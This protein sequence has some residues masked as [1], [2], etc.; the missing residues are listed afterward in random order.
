MTSS[1]RDFRM[2]S[3]MHQVSLKMQLRCLQKL[4]M[5]RRSELRKLL[6]RNSR[7]LTRPTSTPS[8]QQWHRLPSSTTPLQHHSHQQQTPSHK[9]QIHSAQQQLP[10]VQQQLRSLLQQISS[11]QQQLPSRQRQLHRIPSKLLNTH[12]PE[13]QSSD[14]KPTSQPQSDSNSSDCTTYKIA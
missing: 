1:E 3:Q 8:W 4:L 13:P 2:M 6:P 10:S 14:R 5:I 9:Q 11:R 12:P 7:A